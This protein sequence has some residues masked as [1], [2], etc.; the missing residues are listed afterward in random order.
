MSLKQHGKT[1]K[2]VLKIETWMIDNS[3]LEANITWPRRKFSSE[4]WKWV[5]FKMLISE[6]PQIARVACSL[7][8]FQERRQSSDNKKGAV[9][10]ATWRA[11]DPKG[12]VQPTGRHLCKPNCP[13]WWREIAQNSWR[14]ENTLFR[15]GHLLSQDDCEIFKPKEKGQAQILSE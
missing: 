14:E 9:K 6:N 3:I 12:A 11:A 4:N 10:Q 15:S 2:K 1:N 8:N 13:S 7:V 5:M